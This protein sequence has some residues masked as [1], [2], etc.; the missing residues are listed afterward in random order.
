MVT[1]AHNALALLALPVVPVHPDVLIPKGGCTYQRLAGSGAEAAAAPLAAAE[2]P[3]CAALALRADVYSQTVALLLW[4]WVLV[5][6]L[7]PTVLLLS[8]E[9][10][11]RVRWRAARQLAPTGRTNTRTAG[12][13]GAAAA[14]GRWL[15]RR[16]AEVAEAGLLQLLPERAEGRQPRAEAPFLLLFRWWALLLVTWCACCTVAPHFVP[17]GPYA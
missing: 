13:F 8:K 5:G 17:R 6:W 9:R 12:I 10:A 11:A 7:L 1:E 3:G 4:S 16:L 2:G 15:A 14:H